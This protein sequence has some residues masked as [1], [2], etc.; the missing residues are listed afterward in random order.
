MHYF[1]VRKLDSTYYCATFTLSGFCEEW[2]DSA[3]YDDEV[4][5][6]TIADGLKN[7]YNESFEVEKC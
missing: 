1:I 7:H 4:T 5:A 3:F 2:M 6:Q